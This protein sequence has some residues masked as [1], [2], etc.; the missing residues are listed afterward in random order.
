MRRGTSSSAWTLAFSVLSAGAATEND[1]SIVLYGLIGIDRWLFT[2]DAGT[3][4]ENSIDWPAADVLKV[5]HHGSSTST[6]ASLLASAQPRF[7]VISVGRTNRYGHPDAEVLDRL[8]ASG[9]IVF[10]TDEAGTIQFAYPPWGGRVVSGYAEDD[11][12]RQCGEPDSPHRSGVS[13]GPPA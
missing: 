9:A 10:R 6:S 11:L 7:A 5:G 8:S 4:L 3:A 13:F 1:G 12:L 2:G